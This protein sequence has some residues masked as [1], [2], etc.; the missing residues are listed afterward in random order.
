MLC[1]TMIEMAKTYNLKIYDYILYLL[2]ERPSKCMSDEEL[3]NLS[4]WSEGIQ[5][6]INEFIN[7][8]NPQ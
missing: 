1:Y 4:P 5:D 6:R 7:S 8:R 2:S 3:D